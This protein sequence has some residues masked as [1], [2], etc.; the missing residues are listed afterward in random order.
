[1]SLMLA[2]GLTFSSVVFSASANFNRAK[3][4]QNVTSKCTGTLYNELLKKPKAQYTLEDEICLQ[5]LALGKQ[6]PVAQKPGFFSSLFSSPYVIMAVIPLFGTLLNYG[7]GYLYKL[8]HSHKYKKSLGTIEVTKNPIESLKM[9][10][11]LTSAVVGQEEALETCKKF[12]LSLQDAFTNGRDASKRVLYLYGPSGV[13]KSMLSEILTKSITGINSKPVVIEPSDIDF[14]SKVSPCDQIFGIKTAKLVDK[15]INLA[16]PFVQ[17]LLANKNTPMVVIINEFDKF[18]NDTRRMLEEKIRTIVDHGHLNVN[19]EKNDCSKVVF[20]ITSNESSN[21]IKGGNQSQT[22]LKDHDD[23]T[24]SRT[25]VKHDESFLNRTIPIEFKNLD[26]MDYLKILLKPF[27]IWQIKFQREYGVI[28]DIDNMLYDVACKVEEINKG[29]RP[30]FEMVDSLNEKVL[31]EVVLKNFDGQK[32]RGRGYKVSFDKANNKFELK[33]ILNV[34]LAS[35]EAK[36]EIKN[37]VVNTEAAK[38]FEALPSDS[39]QNVNEKAPI[40][41]ETFDE[42]AKKDVAQKENKKSVEATGKLEQVRAR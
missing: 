17:R 10:D 29:A 39:E 3:F 13:G 36:V 40:L 25:I 21:S 2:M 42:L 7:I 32:Y 8:Y 26:K 20:I 16:S 11:M 1:M 12:V 23:G 24:G 22:E 15:E 4:L 19:G 5:Q 35:S 14:Q 34:P 41:T 38:N 31:T 9:F 28:L 30:I 27:K 33:E 37:S 18:D 6:A